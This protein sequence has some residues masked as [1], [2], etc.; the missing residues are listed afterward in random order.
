MKIIEVLVIIKFAVKLSF[1]QLIAIIVMFR[2]NF[3]DKLL[4]LNPGKLQI[5][6]LPE[7][8]L[9]SVEILGDVH[10]TCYA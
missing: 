4:L 3:N 9:F 1:V 2:E 8:P 6:R 10:K 5:L 7:F